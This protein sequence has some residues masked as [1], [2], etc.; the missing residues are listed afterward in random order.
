MDKEDLKYIDA[1]ILGCSDSDLNEEL[2]YHGQDDDD[3]YDRENTRK[4][5][6]F[7]P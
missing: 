7:S 4:A 2:L 5:S 6:T 3:M 1:G